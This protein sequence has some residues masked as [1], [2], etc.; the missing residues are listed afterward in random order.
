MLRVAEEED[1]EDTEEDILVWDRPSIWVPRW[2]SQLK[3]DL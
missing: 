2:V 3:E 1:T